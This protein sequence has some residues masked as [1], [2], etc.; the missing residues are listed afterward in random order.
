MKVLTDP[1]PPSHRSLCAV[2]GWSFLLFAKEKKI[3][4]SVLFP[5]G[6]VDA[7]LAAQGT[8]YWSELFFVFFFLFATEHISA[9]KKKKTCNC[10][11]K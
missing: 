11:A 4:K 1:E 5:V 8:G 10:K 3:T 9:G 6:A 2:S 7:C